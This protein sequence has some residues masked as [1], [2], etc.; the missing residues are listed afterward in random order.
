MAAGITST[1]WDVADLVKFADEHEI[2]SN[3]HLRTFVP[4]HPSVA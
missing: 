4:Q 1:V 3:W 2:M